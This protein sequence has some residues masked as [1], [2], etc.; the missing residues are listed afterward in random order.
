MA[1]K[2]HAQPP[3]TLGD[4]VITALLGGI[5]GFA[6]TI[7]IWF[8]VMYV[9]GRRGEDVS[10]PFYW[11]F[12]VGGVTASLAFVAG[13]ERTMD[14]FEG[15]WGFIGGFFWTKDD[16]DRPARRDNRR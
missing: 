4:R 16:S 12:I 10:F 1:P 6:T 7:V 15:I 3:L 9:G 8:V 13:P 2:R 11:T 14:A 5:C